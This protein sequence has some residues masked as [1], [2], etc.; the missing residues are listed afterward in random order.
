[1]V[2]SSLRKISGKKK[3][4]KH[5][6]SR[7]VPV[8]FNKVRSVAILASAEDEKDIKEILK[9]KNHNFFI[10]KE[11]IVVCWLKQT[12]KK[13]HPVHSGILFVDRPDFDTNYLPGTKRVRDFCTTSFDLLLDLNLQYK[14]PMHALSVMSESKFKAGLM[15]KMNW[16]LPLKIKFDDDKEKSRS[17]LFEQILTYLDRIL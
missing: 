1:M 13:P 9:I 10:D 11:L 8:P 5:K 15:E 7:Q 6:S 12:K 4:K 17:N 14:F 3:L 16:H 2:I